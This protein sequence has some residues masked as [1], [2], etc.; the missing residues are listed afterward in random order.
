[1]LDIL[2]LKTMQRWHCICVM[3]GASNCDVLGKKA[4]FYLTSNGGQRAAWGHCPPF[5]QALSLLWNWPSRLAD[6]LLNARDLPLS[7]SSALGLQEYASGFPVLV[8]SGHHFRSFMLTF[9]VFSLARI[10]DALAF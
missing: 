10:I 5:F 3:E 2:V 9:N 6:W 4:G 7:A 8:S 1:M